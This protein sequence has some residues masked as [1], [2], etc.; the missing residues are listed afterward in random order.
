MRMRI[1]FWRE[2]K[3]YIERHTPT[4]CRAGR[5]GVTWREPVLQ[6]LSVYFLDMI[7]NTKVRLLGLLFQERCPS[8]LFPFQPDLTPPFR[9]R[10]DGTNARDGSENLTLQ[11][12][13]RE[14]PA[15]F[16]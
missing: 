12:I 2:E 7:T 15:I 13:K 4:E 6:L 3:K 11:G 14:L 16:K 8:Y 9:T 10:E 5:V 1:R